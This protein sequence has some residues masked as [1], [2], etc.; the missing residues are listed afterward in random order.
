MSLCVPDL[1]GSPTRTLSRPATVAEI[2]AAEQPLLDAQ[3]SV[4]ELMRSAASAVARVAS[5]MLGDAQRLI[6]APSQPHIL[7]LAGA[8]GNGGD[9]LYAAAMLREQGW[10]QVSAY[11]LSSSVH[12]PAWQRFLDAGGTEVHDP[13]TLAPVDLLID[14]ITGIGARPG[15]RPEAA[16]VLQGLDVAQVLAVD[17]PSGVAADSGVAGEQHVNADVTVSFGAPRLAHLLSAACGTVLIADIGLDSAQ[18]PPLSELIAQQITRRR[19]RTGLRAVSGRSQLQLEGYECMGGHQGIADLSPGPE[20]DKY[21]GGVVGIL[22]G[23]EDYIGAGVL[24]AM[25][26]VRASSSMV[27]YVGA[28]RATVVERLPEVVSHP[29]LGACGQV[30]CVVVGP[31]RGTDERAREELLT[32]LSMDVPVVVD[33][34]AITLLAELPQVRAAVAARQAP[35][36]LT[37]HAGEFERLAAALDDELPGLAENRVEACETLATL[38]GVTVLLKG[39]ATIIADPQHTTIVH[40]GVS[41]AATAGSGDVLAGILGAHLAWAEATGHIDCM[42]AVVS[43]VLVHSVAA[44]LAAQ[45]PYGPAP[46]SASAIAESIPAATAALI[47]HRTNA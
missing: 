43:A 7:V 10:T 6:D 2:R 33:A 40:T 35:T 47:A 18:L 28:L 31:G 1:L 46:T 39:H 26:A 22:A 14:A 23:S 21:S 27:R 44:E 36:V 32:A 20:D 9:G 34:D 17:I 3:G 5:A 11:R 19:T 15:L 45:T 29:S 41:W 24:C 16:A 8:G 4:D 30:Q 13:A 37:P 12:G 25:A 38:L 42:E